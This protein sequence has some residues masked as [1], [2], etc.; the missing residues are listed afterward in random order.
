MNKIKRLCKLSDSK[1]DILMIIDN[2][3]KVFDKINNKYSN[4]FVFNKTVKKD[5]C[6]VVTFTAEF[7]D[8]FKETRDIFDNFSDKFKKELRSMI[9][10]MS[11]GGKNIVVFETDFEFTLFNLFFEYEAWL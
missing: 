8:L 1:Y 10:E 7:T 3:Q 6:N 5:D 2:M 4:L 11:F 9:D